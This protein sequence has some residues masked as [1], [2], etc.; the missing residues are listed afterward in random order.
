MG[1]AER[2]AQAAEPAGRAGRRW[3]AIAV[4]ALLLALGRSVVGFGQDRFEGYVTSR[5]GDREHVLRPGDPVDLVFVDHD[6]AGTAY[7]VVYETA[8][9]ET[10]ERRRLRGRTG[11]AGSASRLRVPASDPPRGFS[12]RVL[13]RWTV[14]GR[15]RARWAFNICRRAC[16]SPAFRRRRPAAPGRQP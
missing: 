7:E 14:A 9:A 15:T 13:V 2:A 10:V 8:Y 11:A 3:R 4:V 6:R 16:S 5:G 1:A 12:M